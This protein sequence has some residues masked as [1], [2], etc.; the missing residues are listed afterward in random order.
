MQTRERQPDCVRLVAR[1]PKIDIAES[2]LGSRQVQYAMRGDGA[3]VMRPTRAVIA[4]SDPPGEKNTDSGAIQGAKDS[5][6][7]PR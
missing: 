1:I 3:E 4:R 5:P 7:R 6:T 2:A